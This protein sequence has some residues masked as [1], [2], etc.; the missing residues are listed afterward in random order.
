MTK[1]LFAGIKDNKYAKL[2]TIVFLLVRLL[3]VIIVVVFK[4]LVYE[5]K[6]IS[7]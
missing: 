3:S 7:Y 6:T 4:D 5:V 2:N 1:E